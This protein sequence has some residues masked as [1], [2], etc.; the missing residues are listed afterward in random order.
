MGVTLEKG[1]TD[2]DWAKFSF[3][4]PDPTLLLPYDKLDNLINFV[5]Y[6]VASDKA[7]P[8]VRKGQKAA[9]LR[10]RR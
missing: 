6:Y 8:S 3:Q 4:G 7:K 9:S 1:K 5:T 10:M 2:S